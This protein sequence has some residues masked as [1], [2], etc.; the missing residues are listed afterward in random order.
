MIQR[1][2]GQATR[3]VLR[4]ESIRTSAILPRDLTIEP[5]EL[6]ATLRVRQAGVEKTYPD[7]IDQIYAG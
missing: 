4:A 6:S 2:V 3:S 1:A 5:G 7:E